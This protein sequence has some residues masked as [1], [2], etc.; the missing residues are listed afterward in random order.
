MNDPEQEKICP[1]DSELSR[2]YWD[3]CRKGELL[4]QHCNSC[5][6]FQFYPRIICAQCH[7][8][9][10]SWR[11]VSGRGHVASFTVVRHAISPAYKA[12]YI[13][14]LIDLEEGVRMMSQV[15][16]CEPERLAIGDPV[17]VKFEDWGRGYFMPVFSH[18]RSIEG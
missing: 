2:P 8:D 3:G 14:A 9:N 18:R 7:G 13:V 10:L 12:P 4:L 16:G 6:R 1:P 5:T 15:V 11:S 17:G